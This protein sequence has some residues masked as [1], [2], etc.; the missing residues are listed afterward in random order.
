MFY[1][2]LHSEMNVFWMHFSHSKLFQSAIFEPFDLKTDYIHLLK[3]LKE[4]KLT[5]Y[6]KMGVEGENISPTLYIQPI[7]LTNTN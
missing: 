3:A 7:V 5:Q 2:D 4:E 1:C 6:L